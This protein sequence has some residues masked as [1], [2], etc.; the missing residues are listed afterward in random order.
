MK[1]IDNGL[2]LMVVDE[3]VQVTRFVWEKGKALI[4]YPKTKSHPF[5]P[6]AP[7]TLAAPECRIQLCMPALQ[8]F[9]T[10]EVFGS[11][12]AEGK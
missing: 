1:L 9:L 10:W 2:S 3:A 6:V 4:L 8:Q 12:E 5:S 11:H 7:N